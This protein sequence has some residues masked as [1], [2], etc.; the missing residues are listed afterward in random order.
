MDWKK[1]APATTSRVRENIEWSINYAYNATDLNAPRVLL[2][3]DSICNA[4]QQDVR[5]YLDGRVNVSFWASSRCVTDPDYFC[6][7]NHFV[8]QSPYAMI[9]FNN[10][11]HSFTTAR[12]EWRAAYRAA[13]SFISDS[14]PDTRLSLVLCT[15]LRDPVLTAHAAQMNDFARSLAQ[16]RGLDV[17]D[18]FAPMD[19]L[20]RNEYWR[21]TYH[22]TPDAVRTQAE[23]IANH[24]L[25]ALKAENTG[26]K[27]AQTA[28][29]PDGAMQ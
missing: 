25:A 2:V 4:Y 24:V 7:L 10:G 27:R 17:V 22:F 5:T 21:D 18:L 23:I 26:F 8:E 12:D 20:D 14:L 16:E 28:T 29:G 19:K 13:V 11:L 6:E 15:P 1:Y 9:C 3:G